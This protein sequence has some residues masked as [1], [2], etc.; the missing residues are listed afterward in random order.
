MKHPIVIESLKVSN[1]LK[2]KFKVHGSNEAQDRT[3]LVGKVQAK[4][5]RT[6]MP[7][8]GKH[9][10]VP[11]GAAFKRFAISFCLEYVRTEKWAV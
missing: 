4:I 10:L 7:A 5:L 3:K 8:V 2:K 1:H 9:E 6:T 11:C